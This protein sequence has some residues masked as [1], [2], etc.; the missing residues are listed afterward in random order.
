MSSPHDI[1][2][3]LDC[4]ADCLDGDW[5]VRGGSR[6]R[7]S[8]S[9][10][11]V[12]P[13]FVECSAHYFLFPRSSIR[14]SFKI[15]SIQESAASV[16]VRCRERWFFPSLISLASCCK[17]PVSVRHGAHAVCPRR[18]RRALARRSE[19]C[20]M[21]PDAPSVISNTSPFF[22]IL[23]GSSNT[24]T[25][26]AQPVTIGASAKGVSCRTVITSPIGSRA[27]RLSV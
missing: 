8:W 10:G 11:T 23:I 19:L 13:S 24:S 2:V 17:I 14:Q 7:H 12:D 27:V 3:R 26:G 21:P 5:S 16:R 6:R 4:P 1:V 22:L 15:N 9:L 18:E 25:F 20:V